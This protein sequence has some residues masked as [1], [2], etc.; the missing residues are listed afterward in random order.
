MQTSANVSRPPITAER[1][2]R[3]EPAENVRK[4]RNL[5]FHGIRYSFKMRAAGG[6]LFRMSPIFVSQQMNRENSGFRDALRR[7]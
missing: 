5:R 4:Q 3:E 7:P 2:C 1:I 6:E